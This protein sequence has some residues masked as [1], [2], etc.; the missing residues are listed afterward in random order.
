MVLLIPIGES[1]TAGVTVLSLQGFPRPFKGRPFFVGKD[2]PLSG[3]P[4]SGEVG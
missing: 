1:F 2:T 3:K 4:D